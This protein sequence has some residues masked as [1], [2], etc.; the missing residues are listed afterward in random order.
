[1]RVLALSLL[2]S[3]ALYAQE[4]RGS[5]SGSVTDAQGAAVGK[6][7]IVVTETRTGTKSD[8][9]SEDSGAFTVPFLAAGEYEI[10]AE[11]AGFKKF[12]RKGVSLGM[13]EHPVI[14]IHMEL[15]AVNES[16]TVVADSP[17]IEAGNAS[18][19]QVITSEE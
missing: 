3:S 16:V 14:D 15:G 1:M 8:A 19:G 4:F 11:A 17:L 5:F 9:L 2:F 18:I 13:G 7:R 6:A 10:T 12:V